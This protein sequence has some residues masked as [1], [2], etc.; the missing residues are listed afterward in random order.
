MSYFG[1]PDDILEHLGGELDAS[2]DYFADDAARA[3]RYLATHL[4]R[5]APLF[6]AVSNYCSDESIGTGD[7]VYL[8]RH[9]LEQERK[10]G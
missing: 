9:L 8:H 5:L 2:S 6:E 3:M 4:N 10:Q 1:E 7:I